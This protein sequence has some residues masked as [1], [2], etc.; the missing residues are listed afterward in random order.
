MIKIKIQ[1]GPG[2]QMFQYALAKAVKLNTNKDI[3]L[4]LS[5]YNKNGVAKIDTPRG[6]MLNDFNIDLE[7][8]FNISYKPTPKKVLFLEKITRRLFRESSLGFYKKYMNV[9]DGSYLIGFWNN[10]KYFKDISNIIR[11]DFVLKNKIEDQKDTESK[12]YLDL[13][14]SNPE[15]VSIYVRREDYL[16]NEYANKEHGLLGIDYYRD[17]FDR[18]IKEIQNRRE[19]VVFVFASSREDIKW[20]KDNFDF[21]PEGYKVYFVPFDIK[22]AEYIYLISKCK[23][24]IISNSTFTWWGAWLNNNTDKIVIAP[25][26]WMRSSMDREDVCPSEWIRLENKFY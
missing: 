25:K 14:N 26:R 12:K 15:S 18:L 22:A 16:S 3:T 23:Y 4:D 11:K 21:I 9:K 7:K 8:D 1:A 10:E 17:A 20:C 24:N 5:F 6:F 2:N 19:L 13:I